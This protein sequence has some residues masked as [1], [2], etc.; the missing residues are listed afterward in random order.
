MLLAMT[1]SA[2]IFAVAVYS[3][4]FK[5]SIK[6]HDNNNIITVVITV[7]VTV[8]IMMLCIARDLSFQSK[9]YKNIV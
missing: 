6:Q 8:T 7:T 4:R 9:T 3:K 2:I 5:F 1:I